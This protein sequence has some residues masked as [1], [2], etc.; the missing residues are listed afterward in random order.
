MI[1]LLLTALLGWLAGAVGNLLAETLPPRA[2]DAPREAHPSTS[3]IMSPCPGTRS[4]RESAPAAERASRS[5]RPL[6]E[7]ATI[8]AFVAGW[9][10]FRGDPAALAIFCLSVLVLPDDR[11]H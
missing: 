4:A 1:E 7:L 8:V 3:H 6:L 2:A 11:R 9:F 10:R 5:A